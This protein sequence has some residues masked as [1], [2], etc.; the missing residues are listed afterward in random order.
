VPKVLSSDAAQNEKRKKKREVEK[1]NRFSSEA[2]VT[3]SD[4][5]QPVQKEG[6]P[7]KG[8]RFQ[9]K[10]KGKISVK[11]RVG[12]CFPLLNRKEKGVASLCLRTEKTDEGGTS[13]PKE[14]TFGE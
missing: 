8:T 12:G 3:Q 5:K 7:K 1:D 9:Q 4:V 13:A 6:E 10:K 2:Y 11:E 14:D